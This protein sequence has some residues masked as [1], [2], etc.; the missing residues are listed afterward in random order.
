MSVTSKTTFQFFWQ[1]RAIRKKFGAGVSLHSHTMYSEESLET[2]LRYTANVPYL[3]AAVRRQEAAYGNRTGRPFDFGQAFWTPPLSPRQAY[4]LE[5]KQINR[6]FELPG[7]ISITDH[8]DMRAGALLRVLERFRKAPVST[9]WTIPFGSTFFHLGVHN[10]PESEAAPIAKELAKFT[11]EAEQDTLEPLFERLNSYPDLL[12][13][14]TIRCGMR[15]RSGWR[16]TLRNWGSCL[17]GTDG[18]FMHWS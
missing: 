2:A 9:E 11:A 14:L 15:K 16:I 10:I 12:L 5:E 13:V 3:G 8:D 4:R 7:I 18:I 6:R 17:N 1:D